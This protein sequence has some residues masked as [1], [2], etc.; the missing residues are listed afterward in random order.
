MR[1]EPQ[2]ILTAAEMRALE[3]ACI[4][5]GTSELELMERAGRAAARAIAAFG[6]PAPTLVLCGPGNNGGDGYVIARRLAKAGWPV[7]IA[8]LAPPATA[9]AKQAAARWS[10][11]VEHI[12]PG[13]SPASVLVD[14]LFGIG[15][16]R[17]IGDPT[18]LAIHRLAQAARTRVA[19]DLPSG[20]ATD[21]GALLSMPFAA[22]LC[23]T[24]GAAKPAHFL[25]PGAGYAGRLVVAGI[26]LE[27]AASQLS[28]IEPPHFARVDPAAHKYQRG[29][30]LVVGGPAHATG[31][32]RLAALA[33]LRA[34]A[35]YVTLLS[36]PDALAANAAHL[37]GVVLRETGSPTAI[38]EA[39]EEPRADAAVIGPALGTSGGRDKVLAVLGAGKPA[40]L[41]ADVF[42]LF[43][44]DPAALATAID[45]GPVV[46]TPHEGEFVRLFGGLPGSKV[47]RTRAAADKVGAVVLLKGADTV[48]A[49]PGGRA[50]ISARTSPALATA[51]S[52]DVLAGI[53]AA[54]LA[55]GLDPLDAACA[56]AW[57][58][59]DAGR[60]GGVGLTAEDLPRLL[61]QV[62]AA[63]A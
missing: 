56:G 25:H 51:G 22:D 42:T 10:G 27:P 26:G 31:A 30:V 32:A 61:P 44:G 49:A 46:L 62:L 38:A 11:P 6:A 8:A 50:A 45:A 16:T 1:L 5:A 2:P 36:P 13:T 55:R 20:V 15:L 37:T 39:L 54:M 47:D 40:V 52:G 34:G 35:G 63:L 28:L 12:G 19:I 14:A 57:L 17:G 4:E 58:H 21:D 41:D 48:V 60:R 18:M 43:A 9:T 23:V 59:G 53:I 33:A 24:F 7:R 3:A 29:H